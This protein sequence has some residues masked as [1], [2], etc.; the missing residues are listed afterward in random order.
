MKQNI[1]KILSRIRKRESVRTKRELAE[2]LNISPQDFS[3]R[4]KRGTLLPLLLE[5]AMQR[6]ISLDWLVWDR[7]R[8]YEADLLADSSLP[9]YRIREK[10]SACAELSDAD[11][12][13]SAFRASDS[14]EKGMRLLSEILSSGNADVIQL[15]LTQLAVI[16]DFLRKSMQKF[17]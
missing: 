17:P 3:Q 5:W 13:S 8:E 4:E 10:S 1:D 14:H 11:P 16:A 15:A 12:E 7:E 9:E 6:N 2:I